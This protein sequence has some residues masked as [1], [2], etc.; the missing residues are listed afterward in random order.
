MTEIGTQVVAFPEMPLLFVAGG[1]IAL[2]MFMIR[3]GSRA[4]R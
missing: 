3:R 1:I 4:G 2:A